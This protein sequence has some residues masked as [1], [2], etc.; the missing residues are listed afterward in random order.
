MCKRL[1]LVL[2]LTGGL[3]LADGPRQTQMKWNEIPP[4]VTG[5]KVALVLPA[6]TEIQ[7]KVLSV[8]PEGLRMKISKT[9]NRHDM[10]KG[11]RLVPRQ[12]V[13]VLRMTHYGKWGRIIGTTA[14]IAAALIAVSAQDISVYEGP[15]VVAVPAAIAAGTAGASVGGYFIGKRIDRRETYIRIAPDN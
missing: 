8:E 6:G 9:S 3:L 11:E 5:K 14:P 4:L 2:C 1:G 10:A 12:S 7:G 15:L 13:S